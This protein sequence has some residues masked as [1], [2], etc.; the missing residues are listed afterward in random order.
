MNK[1]K[2]FSGTAH[3][4][5]ADEVSKLLGIPLSKAEI[6]RFGNNE[7]KVTIQEDVR[8]AKCVIIQPTSN[9][10]DSNIME[11]LLFCDALKRSE[12]KKV[13]AVIP[14][15]GYAKQNMQHRDGECV[16]VNVIIR[17]LE[18]VGFDKVIVF[19]IHDEGTGGVFMIPYKNMTAFS[20]LAEKVRDY[21]NK[22]NIPLD[23]IVLLSPDQGAVEKVR[24]FGTTFYG[25]ENFSEVVIEK[26]RDQNIAHKAKP[27]DLYGNVEGKHVVIVDDMIVS[28]STVI[29]AIDLCLERGA[30]DIYCAFIHNDFTKEAPQK[31]QNSKLKKLFSTNTIP[32]SESMKFDKLEQFSIAELIAKEI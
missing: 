4:D 30:K 24:I 25:S 5:L 2:L 9:P 3:K 13:T 32:L 20:F 7:V 18:S 28:G 11:L 31:L 10:K 1:I 14:Y 21:L 29:P 26:K 8:D 6:I 15:F 19:D 17:M 16:S 23:D 22:Q 27:I 12:A